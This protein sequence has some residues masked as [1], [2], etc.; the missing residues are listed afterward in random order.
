MKDSREFLIRDVEQLLEEND[1]KEA[2]ADV[3]AKL[4]EAIARL[5][6]QSRA[7]ITR[8]FDGATYE[9]LAREHG[10]S[11]SEIETWMDKVKRELAQQLRSKV[12]VKH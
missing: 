6:P 4:D 11:A 12:L 7:L 2:V 3:M 8:F 1:V 5:A 10:V 9:Q